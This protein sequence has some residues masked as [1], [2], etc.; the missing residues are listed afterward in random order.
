MTNIELDIED[1][2]YFFDVKLHNIEDSL[3][4]KKW[5]IV[6]IDKKNAILISTEGLS[7]YKEYHIY[8]TKK[9]ILFGNK[10]IKL[11]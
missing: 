7:K 8:T 3:N 6:W 4:G 11:G 10:I 1:F 5:A 2:E 9:Y